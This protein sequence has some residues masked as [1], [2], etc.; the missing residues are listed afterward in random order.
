MPI[1]LSAE[2]QARK[3]AYFDNKTQTP[4]DQGSY[5]DDLGT[6]FG[7]GVRSLPGI[8]TG[9]GDAALGAAFGADRPLDRM[10]SAIGRRT[11]FQP[12]LTQA[13]PMTAATQEAQAAVENAKGFSNTLG[14]Y[15]DNPRAIGTTIA[16]SAAPSLIG[17]VGGGV[18]AALARSAV[19]KGSTSLSA[20]AL[21]NPFIAA[22][23]GEGAVIAGSQ[24]NDIDPTVDPRRAGLSALAA[25]VGGAIIGGGGAKL[26]SKMG[27]GDLELLFQGGAGRGV[28]PVGQAGK[29]IIKRILGG[30][31]VEGVFQEMPQSALEGL[32]TNWAEEKP[33][34][35]G[36]GKRAAE[37]LITGMGMGAIVGPF[38][39]ARKAPT[40]STDLL[41]SQGKP[42][43]YAPGENSQEGSDF[44]G[45]TPALANMPV[46]ELLAN[47]NTLAENIVGLDAE[48]DAE[49]KKVLQDNLTALQS[50]IK[51]RKL[52]PQLISKSKTVS[53]YE[54][55]KSGILVSEANLQGKYAEST[56]LGEKLENRIN[57]DKAELAEIEEAYPEIKTD[58]A[59]RDYELLQSKLQK[60]AKMEAAPKV[61]LTKKQTQEKAAIEA[62]LAEIVADNPDLGA[63]SPLAEGFQE[64]DD[65]EPTVIAGEAPVTEQESEVSAAVKGM[66]TENLKSSVKSLTDSLADLTDEATP[67]AKKRL[68]DTLAIVQGEIE[69]RNLPRTNNIDGLTLVD[70]PMSENETALYAAR[71]AAEARRA[72]LNKQKDDA[73]IT[74]PN[75]PIWDAID[76]EMAERKRLNQLAEQATRERVGA[77][78]P[79]SGVFN[80]AAD[81]AAFSASLPDDLRARVGIGAKGGMSDT[82]KLTKQIMNAATTTQELLEIKEKLEFA[83]DNQLAFDETGLELVNIVLDLRG[84]RQQILDARVEAGKQP[85]NKFSMA[86]IMNS[87]GT[88][89]DK[90]G[91]LSSDDSRVM[92]LWLEEVVT[93]GGTNPVTFIQLAET[94]TGKKAR[95]A[96]AIKKQIK[97]IRAKIINTVGLERGILD[98]DGNVDEDAVAASLPDN[99]LL[100]SKDESASRNK[101]RAYYQAAAK[102]DEANPQGNGTRTEIIDGQ[103]V[104]VQIIGTSYMDTAAKQVASLGKFIPFTQGNTPKDDSGTSGRDKENQVAS[105]PFAG[106][107]GTFNAGGFNEWEEVSNADDTVAEEFEKQEGVSVRSSID[108][109]NTPFSGAPKKVRR[110]ESV[111][112]ALYNLYAE[113]GTGVPDKGQL[114]TLAD[115][116]GIGIKE[117][118]AIVGKSLTEQS[119][120]NLAKKIGLSALSPDQL[121][122]VNQKAFEYGLAEDQLE[123]ARLSFQSIESVQEMFPTLSG[124][125]D[126]QLAYFAAWNSLDTEGEF[127]ASQFFVQ[128][129]DRAVEWNSLV[130]Q[131]QAREAAGET[132]TQTILE[133]EYK[134]YVDVYRNSGGLQQ[135]VTLA[136]FN[137]DKAENNVEV[138]KARS[139]SYINKILAAKSPPS[140]WKAMELDAAVAATDIEKL[141]TDVLNPVLTG[142]EVNL[143][144]AIVRPVSVAEQAKRDA[145][146]EARVARR[147][148]KYMEESISI[149]TPEL[150]AKWR[151]AGLSE[152]YI[153]NIGREYLKRINSP[154]ILNKSNGAVY[155]DEVIVAEPVENEMPLAEARAFLKSDGKLRPLLLAMSRD[156]I[157]NE[158]VPTKNATQFTTVGEDG[159]FWSYLKVG[160]Q[161]Q[162]HV[163]DSSAGAGTINNRDDAGVSNLSVESES[164]F[165]VYTNLDEL[166]DVVT[167]QLSGFTQAQIDRWQ[168]KANTT[169]GTRGDGS[170]KPEKKVLDRREEAK[171]KASSLRT[172]KLWDNHTGLESYKLQG[173]AENSGKW[174]VGILPNQSSALGA[175]GA[176]YTIVQMPSKRKAPKT[177]NIPLDE[178]GFPTTDRFYVFKAETKNGAVRN[179]NKNDA[180]IGKDGYVSLKSAM[181]AFN[182]IELVAADVAA[183]VVKSKSGYQQPIKQTPQAGIDTSRESDLSPDASV[184]QIKGRLVRNLQAGRSV[185]EGLTTKQMERAR[186]GLLSETRASLTQQPVTQA[187]TTA[188]VLE[189]LDKYVP[190]GV[191]NKIRVAQNWSEIE[192]YLVQNDVAPSMNAGGFVHNGNVFLIADNIQAGT[193]GGVIMHEVGVHMNMTPSDIQMFADT[194]RNMSRKNPLAQ[195]ALD[196]VDAQMSAMLTT[197]GVISRFDVDHEVVAY[198]VEHAVNSGIDPMQIAQKPTALGRFFR[199]LIAI[200][201]RTMSGMGFSSNYITSQDIVDAAWGAADTVFRQ[202][203]DEQSV[204]MSARAMTGALN[205]STDAMNTKASGGAQ[206][207]FSAMSHYTRRALAPFTFSHDIQAQA[208]DYLPSS[209]DYFDATTRSVT[210][211]GEFTQ[212]VAKSLKGA[213]GFNPKQRNEVNQYLLDS[214][215][216]EAWGFEATFAG[217]LEPLKVDEGLR[218]RYDAMTAAQQQ[219]IFNIFAT[220]AKHRRQHYQT[221][222]NEILSTGEELI[223]SE[224]DVTKSDLLEDQL[225]EDLDKFDS[226]TGPQ[227]VAWLHLRRSG[228]HAVIFISDALREVMESTSNSSSNTDVRDMKKDSAHYRVEFLSNNLAASNRRDEI[229]RE[230]GQSGKVESFLRTNMPATK[231]AI[232]FYYLNVMRANTTRDAEFDEFGDPTGNSV[233]AQAQM[234]AW[235]KAY[236]QNLSDT[237]IRKAEL[238]RINVEGADGDMISAFT[239]YSASLSGTVAGIE[240]GRSTSAAIQNMRNEQK[241]A[242]QRGLN[243]DTASIYLNQILSKHSQDLDPNIGTNSN[244]VN[245]T[246]AVTSFWM[247]LT[248][249]AYYIQNL[250]QPWMLTLPHIAG[251]FN[252]LSGTSSAMTTNYVI[253][254]DAWSAEH[255]NGLKSWG[256]E[257]ADIE[258]VIAK[259]GESYRPLMESLVRKGLFDIGLDSDMGKFTGTGGVGGVLSSVQGKF[260]HAVRSVEVFNRGV[261]ALTAY[262]MASKNPDS[263]KMITDPTTKKSR[264][265][266]PEEY[267]IQEVILTQGDYSAGNAPS[268]INKFGGLSKLMTQFRKFQLI[269]ISLLVRMVG[270]SFKGASP[271][272]RA[273]ARRQLGYVLATHGIAGGVLGLPMMNLA[274]DAVAAAFGDDD[275]PA[276][277]EVMMRQEIG[278]D[279][280]ADLFL[281][282]MP[283]W[284]GVDVSSKVGMGYTFS[285]LPF[286]DLEMSKDGLY[287]GMAGLFGGPTVGQAAMWIEGASMVSEGDYARGITQMLPK[288]IKNLSKALLMGEN[289]IQRR[290]SARDTAMSAE[291]FTYLDL[292][293]VF[294]GLPTTK[295]SDMQNANAWL[296]ESTTMRNERLSRIKGDY[297]IAYNDQDYSGMQDA[298]NQLDKLNNTYAGLGYKRKT[299]KWLREGPKEQREREKLTVDG[300][301]LTNEQKKGGTLD[302]MVGK[303]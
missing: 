34:F 88:T 109:N 2:Q 194:I 9:L 134:R 239:E 15:I 47:T 74:D 41:G 268:I 177:K 85:L 8:A 107:P 128:N 262:E 103:E 48:S 296:Q 170:V 157:F 138:M 94:A 275:E 98:E 11:G 127:P 40:E 301:R 167:S 265:Q 148:I 193:E 16:S 132:G 196:S 299:N 274:G 105:D 185:G 201:R 121:K 61:K 6:A 152:Q 52:P 285:I 115:K 303:E 241:S 149:F 62:Q 187:S 290:N 259:K 253:M 161:Y 168:A 27:V 145:D 91:R 7:T 210:R 21:A 86:Q 206:N 263:L 240:L 122:A 133:S 92:N 165:G 101:G 56:E 49:A 36:L 280:L 277:F 287:T 31:A 63:A 276:N 223:A 295:I 81:R 248:S 176:V 298:R 288:G 173:V 19:A 291:E 131:S 104:E 125:I 227:K 106:T 51:R 68:E 39:T 66:P 69:Q 57:R 67:E 110:D 183:P 169:K 257:L 3:K 25:G 80:T 137:V 46:Q 199:R 50:E 179:P 142:N 204:R 153:A 93:N 24:M 58:L 163:F 22:G 198:F 226:E 14:A 279:G 271:V 300:V 250:T 146:N 233:T 29:G 135:R 264:R 272:E 99:F 266:T 232:P 215:T 45:S 28:L 224:V 211:R 200:V 116:F 136:G 197:N 160:S 236:I 38:G 246:M 162:L 260:T 55:L 220:T 234:K 76:V 71:D 216:I 100:L 78:T 269:Q 221:L 130:R 129:L 155:S 208:Q 159:N 154:P 147:M 23:A 175:D 282:G 171:Q 284:A 180:I 144:D 255:G 289:G 252:D 33:L 32:T 77:N 150:T 293:S 75:D 53:R 35:Q 178:T 59:E 174:L 44:E 64:A 37:G 123:Q 120:A 20:K 96:D 140:N 186:N 79:V 30:A 124:D 60:L 203:I 90:Q 126:D 217:K 114:A 139:L 83:G 214:Q 84:D 228:D 119:L 256:G 43:P 10:A 42:T 1:Q 18:G 244:F 117:F 195:H 191:K 151:K 249:P 281:K 65:L 26:A 292:F 143:Q 238:E 242:S 218:K 87:M 231:D 270:A 158:W 113:F 82:K 297:V 251:Q 219:V 166:K 207:M 70:S 4:T 190:R 164:L 172:L 95:G 294:I 181:Q 273:A 222:R 102:L 278:D 261:T 112:I 13:A 302:L 12:S 54:K 205:R 89:A 188:A 182:K 118:E 237:S 243:R 247:L 212:D 156:G 209:V 267:A 192:D 225:Q 245:N 229:Q 72:A 283:A 184:A 73:N 141:N 111:Q 5:A 286:T 235:N 230:V 17:G 189:A 254:K 108:G 213:E 258:T 97:R 202:P